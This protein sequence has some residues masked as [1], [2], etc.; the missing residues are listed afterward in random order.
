MLC[1]LPSK[2][3]WEL[4]TLGAWKD[5]SLHSLIGKRVGTGDG[6][7]WLSVRVRKGTRRTLG[8]DIRSLIFDWIYI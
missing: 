3:L 7:V 1:C 2:C 6:G 8:F 4:A 5:G